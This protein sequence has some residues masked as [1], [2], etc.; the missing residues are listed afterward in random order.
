[1]P[2][3]WLDRPL[4]VEYADA[5]GKGRETR[6][7]LLDWYPVGVVLRIEGARTL[8]PRERL[9]LLELAEGGG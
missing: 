8:I 9:A 1:M 7:V 2:S 3:T 5:G 6:G 4:R